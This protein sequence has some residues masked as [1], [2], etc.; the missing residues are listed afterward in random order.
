MKNCLKCGKEFTSHHSEK[1]RKHKRSPNEGCF[2]SSKCAANYGRIKPKLP[3]VVCAF[4]EK[5]F[6]KTTSNQ[7][8]SKSGLY[9]CCRAHKDAAQRIGGIPEIMPP[10]YGTGTGENTYR[11]ILLRENP[12]LKCRNCSYDA[13]PE[14]LQVHHKDCNHQNNDISNLILLCPT[15]HQVEHFKTRTGYWRP[16]SPKEER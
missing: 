6:Y 16:K 2:C 9:F 12:E 5:A 1:Y 7:S 14:V 15:C 8:Y 13:V 4:C 3:N 11:N 10:H